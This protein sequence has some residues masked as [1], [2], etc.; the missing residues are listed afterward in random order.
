MDNCDVIYDQPKNKSFVLKLNKYSTMLLLPLL[1][2][3]AI[4]GISQTKLYHEL[5]LES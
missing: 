1:I 5:R 3:G 4:R 2:T